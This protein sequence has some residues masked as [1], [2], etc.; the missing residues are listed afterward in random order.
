MNDGTAIRPAETDA[1]IERCFALMVQLRSQLQPRE[2]LGRVRQQMRTGYRLAYME[3]DGKPAAVAGFRVS[4][5]L[6]LGRF[7]Y[8]DDRVTDDGMRSRGVGK[9]L[10]NWLIEVAGREGCR[11]IELDSSVQRFDA[12]RF[13]LRERMRIRSHHFSLPLQ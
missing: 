3:I 8:V 12:H 2:F 9:R 5:N 1:E 13:Y 4:E 7:L 6:F 11:S 10:F